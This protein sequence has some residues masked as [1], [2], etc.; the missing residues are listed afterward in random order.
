MLKKLKNL[1]NVVIEKL[2]NSFTNKAF[3][4]DF[5]IIIVQVRYITL[6]LKQ[7]R[8][9]VLDIPHSYS[10]EDIGATHLYLHLSTDV[11]IKSG[12]PNNGRFCFFFNS[13]VS[14]T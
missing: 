9:P 1:T 8:L 11:E 5:R 14:Y 13:T 6:P 3:F 10:A 2:I 12:I 4:N 7:M